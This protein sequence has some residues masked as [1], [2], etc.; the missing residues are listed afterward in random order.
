[1]G[2]EIVEEYTIIKAQLDNAITEA[3]HAATEGGK[4]IC[5][6]LVRNGYFI[7]LIQ[8][9]NK[10]KRVGSFEF[11]LREIRSIQNAVE[12]LRYRIIGTWHSHPF[13]DAKPGEEDIENALDDEVMLIISVTNKNAA[14]WQVENKQVLQLKFSLLETNKKMPI[15]IYKKIA[16]KKSRIS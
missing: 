16:R 13:S 14:L 9:R 15:L 1:M 7:D 4:E 2:R 5:G 12:R 3:V 11:Y 10:S 6:L 8:V